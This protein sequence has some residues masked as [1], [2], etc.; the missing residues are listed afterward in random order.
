MKRLLVFMVSCFMLLQAN[1]QILIPKKD[2]VA[3]VG[4]PRYSFAICLIS[5]SHASLTTYGILR[6]NPDSTVKFVF[7]TFDSF[8]HQV[9]G[10][11]K[12]LAN[13]DKVNYIEE[14]GLEVKDFKDLWKLKFDTYPYGQSREV[15]Y[16][17]EFGAPSRG[18]YEMLKPYGISRVSDYCYGEKLWK[19]MLNFK[20][21]QWI[22]MYEQRK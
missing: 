16:G 1:G 9:A 8:I 7:L 5:G 13:P 14:F 3:K 4:T 15:G 19:L 2:Y 11:E 6:Q 17:T 21:P 12:S 18:Q 20:D 10:S 22:G